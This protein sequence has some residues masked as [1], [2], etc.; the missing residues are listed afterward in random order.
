MKPKRSPGAP[1][2]LTPQVQKTFMRV[3]RKG[4]LRSACVAVGISEETL[5]EW[6]RRGAAK[7]QPY[8]GFTEALAVA[9]ADRQ[10]G[11]LDESKKRGAKKHDTREIQWRAAV[12]DPEVFSIKHHLVVQQQLDAAIIRIK[13]RFRDRPLILE[14]ILSAIVGESGS[15]GAGAV[16]GPAGPVLTVGGQAAEPDSIEA[17]TT[18]IGVPRPGG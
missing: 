11:Y 3:V 7:E 9:I 6:R 4:F 16:E 10:Q 18:T 14:E 5:S 8:V 2:K 15:G 12:T 17:V 1:T 13:E